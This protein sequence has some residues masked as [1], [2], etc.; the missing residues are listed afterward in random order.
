MGADNAH[1]L[2]QRGWP[3]SH[4]QSEHQHGPWQIFHRDLDDE[5]HYFLATVI[6]RVGVGKSEDQS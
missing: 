6:L 5:E 2:A 1:G 3:S 4:D